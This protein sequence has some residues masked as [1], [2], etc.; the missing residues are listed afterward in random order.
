MVT[1]GLWE[2]IDMRRENKRQFQYHTKEMARG[3]KEKG[4]QNFGFV[5]TGKTH[6]VLKGLLKN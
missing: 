6:L 4:S 5:L 3:I 1:K 2:F